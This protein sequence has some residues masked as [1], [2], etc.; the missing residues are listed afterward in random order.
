MQSRRT[1]QASNKRRRGFTLIELLVV[2]SIIATL[3]SLILPA[4]QNAREAARRMQCLNNIRNVSLAATN[5]A[6]SNK[7]RL[8]SLSYYIADPSS[9]STPVNMGQRSLFVELLPFMDQQG[10][11]DRWNR[12]LA[13]ND[14]TVNAT[15]GASN[16][17]L[18]DDLYVEAFVC[19]NDESSFGKGGGLTYVANAGFA[20]DPSNTHS[21][22]VE[23]FDWNGD[24]TPSDSE[25]D[26]ITQDTGV[27]WSE[28][29]T[30]PSTRNASATLGKIYDGT[31]NTLMFAENINAGKNNFADPDM[32]NCGFVFPITGGASSVVAS[33][34]SGG[35]TQADNAAMSNPIGAVLATT[36]PFINQKKT[37]PEG[38]PYI[39]ALHPSIAVV[40]FC[41]GSA[42]TLSESMDKVVYVSLMTP[43]GTRQR[44][45]ATATTTWF[46]ESPVSA[47]DF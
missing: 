17:S 34:P 29:F 4:V 15:T 13:W 20:D 8:P 47:S 40:S 9:T 36:T 44:T 42:K 26:D 16:K 27:F 2:I 19:P 35:S 30:I 45:L 28:F 23:N 5:F 41:D 12:N 43:S 46:P 14:T 6:T 38:A 33:P 18:A 32:N 31:S 7:S 10:T 11:Y 39:N 37:G 22:A 3:M 1:S 25:D 24:G 21:F